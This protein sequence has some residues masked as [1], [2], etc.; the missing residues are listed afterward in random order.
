MSVVKFEVNTLLPVNQVFEK[1]EDWW[2]CI[3]DAVDEI[4]K[5]ES[6]D[7]KEFGLDE[8]TDTALYSHNVVK[9]MN[10]IDANEDDLYAETE[11][12][13]KFIR[14]RQPVFLDVDGVLN[15]E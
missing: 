9:W 14:Y 15:D 12:D 2:Y 6:I 3:W 8:A 10:H 13:G 4:I 5:E 1:Q 7:F 11:S